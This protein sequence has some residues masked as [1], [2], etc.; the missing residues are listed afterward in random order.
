MIWS[1]PGVTDWRDL[2]TGFMPVAVTAA[3][4]IPVPK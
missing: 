3:A 2:E 1:A 4:G